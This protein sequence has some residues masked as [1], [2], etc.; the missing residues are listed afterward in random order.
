[1][2][3]LNSFT[4]LPITRGLL[5]LVKKEDREKIE[6]DMLDY[7]GAEC[8]EDTLEF[9]P[10]HVD[11]LPLIRYLFEKNDL[12]GD[13]LKAVFCA[14]CVANSERWKLNR[15]YEYT[16]K[17]SALERKMVPFFEGS[18]RGALNYR[19]D[20]LITADAKRREDEYEEEIP[21]F[22]VQ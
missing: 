4:D 17:M 19:T 22:E 18:Y 2:K 1:M 6:R 16:T 8:N 14:V 3:S 7:I 13:D 5:L 20:E 11:V 10:C 9:V 15:N 21:T 12:D